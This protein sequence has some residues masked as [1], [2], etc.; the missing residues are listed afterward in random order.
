PDYQQFKLNGITYD[1]RMKGNEY[2]IGDDLLQVYRNYAVKFYKENPDYEITTAMIDDNL[3][4]QRNRLRQ[5]VLLAAYGSDRAQQG[6]AHLDTQLQRA[7]SEMPKAADIAAR[8][9]RRKKSNS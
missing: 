6:M 8:S 7:V 5:E 4:W 9:W 3:T 2:L 1:Y